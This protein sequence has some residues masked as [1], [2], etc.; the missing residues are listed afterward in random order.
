MGPEATILFQQKLIAAVQTSGDC[1]HIPL[2]IDMN[3]QVPS[4]ID[5]L[6]HRRGKDP[7]PVITQMARRLEK[8]GAKALA[9]PCNTAHHYCDA[10]TTSV[11]VPFLNMVE[12]SAQ[13]AAESLG[14]DGCVGMLASPAVRVTGLFDRML[15]RRGLRTLWPKDGPRMLHAI[16]LIKAQGACTEARAILRAAS[17]ELAWQGARFQFIACSE[18]SLIADSICP[19]ARAVDTLDVLVSA[20]RDFSLSTSKPEHA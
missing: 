6:V 10:I 17:G 16:Q 15:E 19:D 14:I 2:I 11:S 1:G 9:M 4:R 20:T 12:L 18:F 7:A 5:H 13:L 8:A 3:P